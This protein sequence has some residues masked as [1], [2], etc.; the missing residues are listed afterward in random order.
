MAQNK[1]I[2]LIGGQDYGKTGTIDGWC[3][4]KGQVRKAG[5][6]TTF[7]ISINGKGEFIIIS[8][9]SV[10]EQK[11]YNLEKI[12]KEIEDRIKRY[13]ERTA[14]EGFERFIW[15]IAFTIGTTSNSIKTEQVTVPI[16]LLKENGFDVLKIYM[17]RIDG[18]GV[19]QFEEINRFATQIKDKE[20]PSNKEWERQAEKLDEY[21][22]EFI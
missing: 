21:I 22:I 2:I 16:E 17:K 15:I 20:I 6:L 19:E 11:S 3:K 12:K 7:V 18:E 5:G 9:S 8:S 10:Q 4:L 13:K 14:K 1:A